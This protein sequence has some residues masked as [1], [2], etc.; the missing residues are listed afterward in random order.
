MMTVL[1][2][3]PVREQ[4]VCVR[5]GFC[6]DGTLFMHAHLND[7]E[8]GNLPEKIEKAAFTEDEKDFFRLPCRYFSGK[9]TIYDC[10][11]ADVC[12]SYRCQLLKD[13]SDGK[14]SIDAAHETV[15]QASIMRESIFKDFRRVTGSRRKMFFRQMLI[16][17][18]RLQKTTSP[19]R[20]LGSDLDMLIARCNIFEA[21]LIKHFRSEDDFE[22][23]VMK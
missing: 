11:R 1:Q 17:L 10:K 22:K 7:G 9:C 14:I 8:R 16:E 15:R 5:C 19:D 20:S 2:T 21:L 6:C 23:M 18:G 4:S 12:S 13:L 3:A